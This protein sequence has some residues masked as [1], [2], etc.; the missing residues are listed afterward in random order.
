MIGEVSVVVDDHDELGHIADCA[1]LVPIKRPKNGHE[2]NV[3]RLRIQ[4][5]SPFSGPCHLFLIMRSRHLLDR[6]LLGKF[7]TVKCLEASGSLGLRGNFW[8]ALVGVVE[9]NCLEVAERF[10]MVLEVFVGL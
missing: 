2:A 8:K 4:F 10:C 3:I 6:N 9:G 1:V 7:S 5:N